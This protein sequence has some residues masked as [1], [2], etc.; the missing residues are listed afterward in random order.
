MFL[1]PSEVLEE[2]KVVVYPVFISYVQRSGLVE[3]HA[4]IKTTIEALD[5]LWNRFQEE[6]SKIA[7]YLAAEGIYEPEQ[8]YVEQEKIMPVVRALQKITELIKEH[9]RSLG[10]SIAQKIAMVEESVLARRYAEFVKMHNTLYNTA[11][12]VL[13][14]ARNVLSVDLMMKIGKIEGNLY[15]ALTLCEKVA[16][17]KKELEQKWLPFD[18]LALLKSLYSHSYFSLAEYLLSYRNVAGTISDQ[19]KI[20]EMLEMA[21]AEGGVL[22]RT[23]EVDLGVGTTFH[24]SIVAYQT[25]NLETQILHHERS[26][27][28]RRKAIDKCLMEHTSIMGE[29]DNLNWKVGKEAK[30]IVN[31]EKSL[32]TNKGDVSIKR[33]FFLFE[34]LQKNIKKIENTLVMYTKL[35]GTSKRAPISDTRLFSIKSL[36]FKYLI[37]EGDILG[38]KA[39]LYSLHQATKEIYSSHTCSRTLFI[40]ESPE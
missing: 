27:S 30:N 8:A 9:I 17:S 14:V 12:S 31:M 34:D 33:L 39:D 1:N 3:E 28:L 11:F 24:D 5:D 23:L 20:L 6:E 40:S 10:A 15:S 7:T 21:L 35:V 2:S 18:R 32:L 19:T 36:D 38:L 22:L 13:S 25:Y 16:R 26:I 37:V 29:I 4:P